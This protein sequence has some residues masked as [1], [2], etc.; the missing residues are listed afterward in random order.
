VG[1][2]GQIQFN[3]GN[4]LDAEAALTW[5]KTNDR[6][7][8][9]TATPGYNVEVVGTAAVSGAV[10]LSSTLTGTT[11]IGIGTSSVNSKAV[12]D[13]VS[14]SKGFLPPRMTGAQLDAISSPPTGLTIFNTTT[15]A[16]N[17]FNGTGWQDAASNF[18]ESDPQVGTLTGSNFCLANAGGTAIDCTT[19]AIA[20][21]SISATGTPSSS[22]YLR[23]DGTWS[24]ISALL[25]GPSCCEAISPRSRRAHASCPR[26]PRSRAS[27]KPRFAQA[28][29]SDTWPASKYASPRCTML[30][31]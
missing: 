6:L 22:T 31:D 19:A 21:A 28:Q 27:P 13:V 12:L 5:D 29:A 16:L 2:T 17:Y 26:S 8:I 25:A 1:S 9:G 24:T 20:L 15:N 3:T 23:G 7:G 4:N 18:V 14:T 30:I 10:T 11:G